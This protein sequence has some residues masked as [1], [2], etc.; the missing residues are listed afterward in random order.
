MVRIKIHMGMISIRG[1]ARTIS[2]CGIG[3]MISILPVMPE[4]ITFRCSSNLSGSSGDN[5]KL[6]FLDLTIKIFFKLVNWL[7]PK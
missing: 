1:F 3:L 5:A 7:I 4:A 6:P 2:S